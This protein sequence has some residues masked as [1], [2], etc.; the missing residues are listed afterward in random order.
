MTPWFHLAISGW[1]S[2]KLLVT[3]LLAIVKKPGA[4]TDWII[5][6]MTDRRWWKPEPRVHTWL[7]WDKQPGRLVANPIQECSKGRTK[8]QL[9]SSLKEPLVQKAFN[10]S[11]PCSDIEATVWPPWCSHNSSSQRSL[12]LCWTRP[13]ELTSMMK[14][15]NELFQ[16]F[17]FA[18][19]MFILQ[20][21]LGNVHYQFKSRGKQYKW[22]YSIV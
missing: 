18:N 17:P 1:M 8:L 7:H 16:N 22:I 12:A 20:I 19:A 21:N 2:L 5:I 6:I 9:I 11:S 15:R 10:I 14:V 13:Q 3:T 4:S